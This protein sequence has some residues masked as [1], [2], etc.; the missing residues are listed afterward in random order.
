MRGEHMKEKAEFLQVQLQSIR[1]Q[2]HRRPE[3]AFQEAQTSELIQSELQSYG[4]PFDAGVAKTGVIGHIGK[5]RPVIAIRADMDALPIEEES[6]EP[7]ASEV[8]GVMHA[9]GHDAHVACLLGAA[10]LLAQED[11]P[12]SIRLLFQPSEESF[13]REGKSGAA[14]MIEE[15]AL[16]GV[17][18]I[19]A[20]HMDAAAPPGTIRVMEGP[21]LASMDE[22]E[23]IVKGKGCHGAYPHKGLDPVFITAQVLNFI[24]GIVSRNINPVEKALISIGRIHGGSASNIIPSQVELKGTIRTFSEEVREK[25]FS[26]IRT[27]ADLIIRLGG[28]YSLRFNGG[29]PVTRND[30]EMVSLIRNVVRDLQGESHLVGMDP[31]MGAEDFGF[32]LRK[33]PGALFY[34]GAALPDES[35]HIHHSAQFNLDDSIL[36]AGSAIL[37]ESALRWM[38]SKK[39]LSC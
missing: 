38:R 34:L 36:Y 23:L 3:L 18:A 4:I 24:Y 25:I 13:D 12:G 32:Y 7:Y 10:A 15:G 26:R 8:K 27:T 16:D 20:L 30:P 22:F 6:S 29:F 11:L 39:D 33:I 9:C 35:H 21:M 17:E 31:Q 2:L 1:R 5:G 19:I 28:S 37:A 14:R